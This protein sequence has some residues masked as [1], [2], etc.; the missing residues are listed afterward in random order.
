MFL[1]ALS[2]IFILVGFVP[3]QWR[4]ANITPIAKVDHPD[5]WSDYRPISLTSN[6]CKT[7]EKVVTR[8]ICDRQTRVNF[9]NFFDFAKAFD[10][11]PHDRLLNKLTLVLPL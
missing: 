3:T 6:L 10:L 9:G 11:V 2:N 8:Y 4:L 7:F 5:S 1:A